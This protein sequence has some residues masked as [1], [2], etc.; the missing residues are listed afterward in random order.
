VVR[1]RLQGDYVHGFLAMHWV[2]LMQTASLPFASVGTLF[3]GLQHV[4][5]AADTYKGYAAYIGC[6]DFVA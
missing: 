4:A 5:H 3:G 1:E 6:F 2:L